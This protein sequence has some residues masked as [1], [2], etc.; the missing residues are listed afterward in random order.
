MSTTFTVI[1]ALVRRLVIWT[2]SPQMRSLPRLVYAVIRLIEPPG[3]GVLQAV[4]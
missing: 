1:F 3:N 2:Q 4:E